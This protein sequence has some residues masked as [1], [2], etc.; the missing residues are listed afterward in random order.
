MGFLRWKMGAYAEAL[1][2]H[3]R[4]LRIRE[5]VFGTESL[6]YS[7]SLLNIGVCELGL[8]QSAEA[9]AHLTHARRLRKE[10]LGPNHPL[11]AQADA[12]LGAILLTR[13]KY[14]AAREHL[15]RTLAVLKDVPGFQGDHAD[16]LERLGAFHLEMGFLETAKDYLEQAL[17]HR[18]NAQGAHHPRSGLYPDLAG[19][20]AHETRKDR[21]R[22]ALLRARTPTFEGIRLHIAKL[23]FDSLSVYA[24]DVDDRPVVISE[25][26]DDIEQP[27]LAVKGGRG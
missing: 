27:A 6:S 17:A 11:L 9:E 2:L 16:T 1:E 18:E 23:K 19:G 10:I 22:P 12:Y 5:R 25:R 13:G 24:P 3:Q 20:V 7:Y 15:T 8:G 14:E 21:S 26:L 4:A